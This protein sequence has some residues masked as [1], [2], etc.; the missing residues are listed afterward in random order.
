MDAFWKFLDDNWIFIMI[1][2]GGGI[3]TAGNWVGK[4][5][6]RR[7]KHRHAL[8]R[9]K[10]QRQIEGADP[11]QPKPICGCGH[12]LAFHNRDTDACHGTNPGTEYVED[13]ARASVT[14]IL[15]DIPCTCQRYTGPEPL[16]QIYAPPL[17][18]LNG[19]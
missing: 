12:D 1:F 13:E 17:T 11:L 5:F 2:G 15:V 8:Q 19:V 6:N 16:G 7:Q 4:Y 10:M 3:G 9:M 18:D 14:R